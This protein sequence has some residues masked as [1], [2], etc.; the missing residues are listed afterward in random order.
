[1]NENSRSKGENFPQSVAPYAANGK[2]DNKETSSRAV[3]KVVRVAVVNSSPIM[4]GPAAEGKLEGTAFHSHSL[5]L[6]EMKKE[7]RIH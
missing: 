6:A 7:K 2:E 1:M 4:F 3:K 5:L